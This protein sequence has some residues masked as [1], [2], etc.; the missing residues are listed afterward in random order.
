MGRVRNRKEDRETVRE[1]KWEKRQNNGGQREDN[2][3]TTGG[4]KMDSTFKVQVQDFYL[5]FVHTLTVQPYWNSCA[6]PSQST[7]KQ[8]L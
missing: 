2:M 5:P 8:P 1:Q 4:N 7:I 6:K 3:D